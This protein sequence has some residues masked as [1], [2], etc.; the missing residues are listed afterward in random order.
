M[1]LSSDAILAL[2]RMHLSEVGSVEA[3]GDGS[4]EG[5]ARLSGG[6]TR[7]TRRLEERKDDLNRNPLYRVDPGNVG[8]YVVRNLGRQGEILDSSGGRAFMG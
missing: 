1:L 7:I 3:G 8:V 5:L 6:S 4:P 2:F